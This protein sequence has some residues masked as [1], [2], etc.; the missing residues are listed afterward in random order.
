MKSNRFLLVISLIGH[1]ENIA[2]YIQRK[3]ILKKLDVSNHCHLRFNTKHFFSFSFFLVGFI[4]IAFKAFL[5]NEKLILAIPRSNS[6]AVNLPIKYIFKYLFYSYSDGLGDSV[7][8]FDLEKSTQY[9]GHIG[10]NKIYPKNV[11]IDIDLV[12]YVEPWANKIVFDKTDAVLFIVKYPKDVQYDSEIV[13]NYYLK[14]LKKYRNKKTIFLSGNFKTLNLA[15]IPYVINIGPIS[16]LVRPIRVSCVIGFPST[17]FITF[18]KIFPKK[19][20]EIIDL[21]RT[22]S[23]LIPFNKVHRMKLINLKLIDDINYA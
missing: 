5:R 12:N 16:K 14:L 22:T 15:K 13:D 18:A 21:P 7:H 4:Y 23:N 8:S 2:F 20:I 17:L 3:D 11:F 19:N 10:S 9:L 6:R 1:F